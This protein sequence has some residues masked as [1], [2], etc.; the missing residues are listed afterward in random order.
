MHPANNRREI[1]AQARAIER[2]LLELSLYPNVIILDDLTPEE[3]AHIRT[4]DR[5]QRHI[6]LAKPWLKCW[7]RLRRI[8]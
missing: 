4:V 6:D 8:K 5:I 2:E 7:A 1:A 3:R